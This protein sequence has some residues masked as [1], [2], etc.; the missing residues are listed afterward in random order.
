MPE[1]LLVTCSRGW[2]LWDVAWLALSDARERRPNVVLLHGDEPRGDRRLAAMWRVLGGRDEP[3]PADWET[4]RRG[5]GII[6]NRLMVA[7]RPVECLA[8]IRAQ[9]P[10]ATDCAAQAADAGVP[11]TRF[12]DGEPG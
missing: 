1:L 11:T 6:R 3:M 12:E 9:S 7:R 8:F 5:G 2:R 10:G 4:H